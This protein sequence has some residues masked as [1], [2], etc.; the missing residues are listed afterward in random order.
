MLEWMRSKSCEEEGSVFRVLMFLLSQ[1]IKEEN[2]RTPIVILT[3]NTDTGTSDTREIPIP[4]KWLVTLWN[5]TLHL[6][7]AP[8]FFYADF[9]LNSR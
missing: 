9:A 4:K 1:T 2:L 8:P 7:H 5:A 6:R 3:K